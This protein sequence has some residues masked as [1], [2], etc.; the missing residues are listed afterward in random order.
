MCRETL[1][2]AVAALGGQVATAEAIRSRKPGAR[3]A[4]GHVWKWLNTVS[5]EV[6]PA[7]YVLAIAGA[8]AWAF[9]PP[10]LRP[11]LYPN[12]SDALPLSV[13]VGQKTAAV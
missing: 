5:S 1:I 4:Q 12:P 3:V 10:D 11:D 8:T 7:E 6:P 9:R 2:K 13:S